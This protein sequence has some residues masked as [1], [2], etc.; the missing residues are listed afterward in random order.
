MQEVQEE[1]AALAE[2]Q[3]RIE[4]M[5]AS[6]MSEQRQGK[7]GQ[8]ACPVVGGTCIGAEEGAAGAE[9]RY[10]Q[11]EGLYCS[12]PCEELSLHGVLGR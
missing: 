2:G 10:G 9:P 4:Q 1:A 7:G 6:A 5:V 8:H 3:Q 12:A 11:R